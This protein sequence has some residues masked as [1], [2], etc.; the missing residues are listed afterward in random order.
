M[1]IRKIVLPNPKMKFDNGNGNKLNRHRRQEMSMSNSI[2]SR[3]SPW[4]PLDATLCTRRS[5]RS[6]QILRAIDR[7]LTMEQLEDRV[8]LRRLGQKANLTSL[9]PIEAP[10]SDISLVLL[11]RTKVANLTLTQMGPYMRVGPERK[12]TSPE[13]LLE[14]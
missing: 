3:W 1:R 9:N 6:Q 4:T 12:R 2:V 14:H 10:T 8:N 5:R 7:S 13:K 11:N